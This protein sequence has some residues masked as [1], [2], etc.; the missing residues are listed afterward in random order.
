MVAAAARPAAARRRLPGRRHRGRPAR[1]SRPGSA[2]TSRSSTSP[3][4][5]TL[6]VT[7]LTL[8]V[9]DPGRVAGLGGGPRHAAGAGPPRC[10]RGCAGGCVLPYALM[11]LA[12]S[13][14]A[15]GCR[16][17]S[18][19]CSARTS[20][21]GPVASFG[22]LL[23]V[24][25]LTTPLQSAAEEYLFRGYLSQAIAGVGAGARAPGRWWPA[26]LTAA[27]FSAA[28]AAARPADLPRPL[29]LRAGGLGGRVADRRAGGGDRAARGQQ[30][31]GVRARR[32]AGGRRRHRVGARRGRA[33]ATCW[34][35]CVGGRLR[36]G[37][38][39]VAAPA[40]ARDAHRGRRPADAGAC[41]FRSP[42]ADPPHPGWVRP[43]R[44]RQV[45]SS[46]APRGATH[47]VWGNWQPDGFWFR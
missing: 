39:A 1:R 44:T 14:S 25:V 13:A 30:R 38:G 20:V 10:W 32:G 35:A 23:V 22:W 7:N 33:A 29:R 28:H 21:T 11:A 5:V 26:S 3:T 17:C 19:S 40:A 42:P 9:A 36:R 27:L 41:P 12:R 31:A 37:G 4:R 34:S 18:R 8:I 15:S 46:A 2:P 45:S 24:V 47:G 16:C 43:A 6:L